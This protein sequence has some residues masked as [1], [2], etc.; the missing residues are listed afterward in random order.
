M[1]KPDH[2]FSCI[3]SKFY[4]GTGFLLNIDRCWNVGVR[5]TRLS[6]ADLCGNYSSYDKH[7]CGDL[8]EPHLMLTIDN[9]G[10]KTCVSCK[11]PGKKPDI[12]L[13]PAWS[14]NDSDVSPDTAVNVMNKLSSLLE[15]M[16]NCSTAAITMGDIKGL[17]TKLPSKNHSDIKNGITTSGDMRILENNTDLVSDFSRSVKIPKEASAMAVKRNG[18]YAGVMLFPRMFQDDPNSFFF[19]DEVVG[20]EMGAE[21]S[22]L[23][24]TIDI[25]YSNVD[26]N[27]S[28]ASCRSWDGNVATQI[29]T[30]DGCKTKETKSS[31]TCQ[32]SHLT[33]FAILLSPPPG[34]ISTSD[35][36][37]LTYITS[38][39]CGLSMFFLAV[40]LFMHCLIRK[41]KASQ[42][43]KI[44]MNLFVAMFTLNLS[45]LINETVANLGNYTACVVMAA[46]MHYTMLATFSWFLAQALHLYYNLHKLPS[47][48]KHYMMKIC[49]TGWVT[50]AVVVIALLATRKYD[51]LVIYTDNGNSATMCWISDAIVHQGVNIGYY[52]GVFIFTLTVFIITVRQI[53]VLKP[54]EAQNSSSI[55]TNSFSILGLFLL[56]GITWAFAFFS[57]GPLLLPSYY[58]FTILNSFQGF[59]LFIYYYNSS[60][61]VDKNPKADSSSSTATANT[62][63]PS[64]FQ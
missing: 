59:F 44:L 52:A 14:N 27:G 38:I 10:K 39:G 64:P 25:H 55:K 13:F 30:T 26:K 8:A 23:S 24:Q 9:N 1:P 40:A 45:F 51:Y 41:G 28:I 36:N 37:S 46:V 11:P 19:N 2:N 22:N 61:T 56:L 58:I 60:K 50:P 7:A 42:A 17:L 34:N 53:A 16:G 4:N 29:W 54:A 31:I 12:S 57:Y 32:C 47:K 35:F 21:I 5:N 6:Q 33:F 48:I 20:I 63:T 62:V 15:L 49:I 43:T 18:S 3:P